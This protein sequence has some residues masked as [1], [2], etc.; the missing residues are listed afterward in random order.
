MEKYKNRIIL[1]L[2]GDKKAN[3]TENMAHFF[4]GVLIKYNA[5]YINKI[6]SILLK[7]KFEIYNNWIQFNM[8]FHVILI[9]SRKYENLISAILVILCKMSC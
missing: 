7:S 4:G 6:M 9:F 2:L 8:V 1:R 5:L 3:K